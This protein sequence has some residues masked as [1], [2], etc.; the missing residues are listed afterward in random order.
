M[1]YK[2]TP[3]IL[4]LIMLLANNTVFGA[5]E[6][7]EYG[8]YNEQEELIY[9]IKEISKKTG[10]IMLCLLFLYDLYFNEQK[11]SG[12]YDIIYKMKLQK[13]QDAQIKNHPFNKHIKLIEQALEKYE[14][15]KIDSSSALLC[16]QDENTV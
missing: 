14:D 15:E 2:K 10:S 3:S 1:N 6:L 16:D 11:W 12:P 9:N 5:P 7:R 13:M 4:L 8:R